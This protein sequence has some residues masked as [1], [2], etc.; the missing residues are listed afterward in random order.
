[1]IKWNLVREIWEQNSRPSS[2]ALLN[3][4]TTLGY[5]TDG[6]SVRRYIRK[7][8]K[9]EYDALSEQA[10]TSEAEFGHNLWNLCKTESG[11]RKKQR[12]TAPHVITIKTDKPIAIPFIADQHLGS[13]EV[14]YERAE[15]DAKEIADTPNMYTV[16]GG[17]SIDNFI[18]LAISSAMLESTTTPSEQLQLLEYYLSLFKG[19]ILAIVSGNHELWLKDMTSFDL[20]K[21]IIN[22][23]II[24]TYEPYTAKIDLYVNNINYKI[25]IRHKYRFNSSFNL[26]H[27]VKRMYDMCDYSFDIGIVCHHHRATFEPFEKHSQ[28][29]WA[30]RTGT[31]KTYDDFASKI[32]FANA[33][34][35]ILPTAIL[36]PD[37]K[38]IEMVGSIAAAKKLIA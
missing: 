13:Y 9:T 30:V 3:I 28:T 33:K 5:K 2:A 36:Y 6:G 31:Y 12:L 17:D 35:E 21:H 24:Q 25:M 34:N 23:K 19:K 22:T 10:Q 8:K 29:R 1:M 15:R 11:A 37:Q 27:T 4:L 16:F 20:Y 38:K 26:T 18:K 7:W 32:G 14:D